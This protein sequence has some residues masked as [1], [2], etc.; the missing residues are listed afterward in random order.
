MP[1]HTYRSA[2]ARDGQ[3]LSSSSPRPTPRNWADW[4]GPELLSP[5]QASSSSGGA[6]K[7]PALWP[8]RPLP[9]TSATSAD[10]TTS[11]ASECVGSQRVCGQLVCAQV[12]SGAWAA[13]GCVGS[14]WVRGR[15]VCARVA[16]GVWVA[17]GCV[18]GQCAWVWHGAWGRGVDILQHL[19]SGV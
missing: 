5:P 3:Y 18:G 6:G 8:W 1:P 16:S 15:P 7:S 14:W 13:G 12:A 17:S 10:M 2:E 9:L 11:T 19:H 4:M